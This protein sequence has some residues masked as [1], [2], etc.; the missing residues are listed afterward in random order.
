GEGA[1]EE[2]AAGIAYFNMRSD[3]DLLIVGRGGGSIEDLWSF[4]EESVARAIFASRLPIISAVGHET[5]FTIA[6]FVADYRAPTP[7]AAAEIA[8]LR[9]DELSAMVTGFCEMLTSAFQLQ[10]LKQRNRL[11]SLR[12]SRGFELTPAL[13]RRY[14]QQLDELTHQLE[15]LMRWS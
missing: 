12:A 11:S 6:D 2:I 3:I 9:K 15:L 8:V 7:W 13:L 5:D 4:N 1:A 14:G 10:L